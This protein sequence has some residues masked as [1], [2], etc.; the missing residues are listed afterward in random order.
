MI[1]NKIINCFFHNIIIKPYKINNSFFKD[2]H[3]MNF[4]SKSSNILRFIVKI[5]ILVIPVYVN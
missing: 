4:A 1:D 5:C 2:K 3:I